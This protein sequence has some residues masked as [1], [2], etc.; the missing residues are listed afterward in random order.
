METP[1]AYKIKSLGKYL[2]REIPGPQ[3]SGL[4]DKLEA[5]ASAYKAN[6]KAREKYEEK[7][8]YELNRKCSTAA[9]F[10]KLYDQ[11]IKNGN[12]SKTAICQ[13]I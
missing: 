6:A 13:F 7:L 12:A 8:I 1:R 10:Q 4:S 5:I 9:N 11:C 2:S 3:V